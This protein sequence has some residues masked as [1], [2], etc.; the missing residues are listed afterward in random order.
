MYA[1]TEIIIYVTI[2]DCQPHIDV[3]FLNDPS[4]GTNEEES[5]GPVHKSVPFC[6]M[7][8]KKRFWADASSNFP[9]PLNYP[10]SKSM[11]HP[12]TAL[13]PSNNIPHTNSFTK[14]GRD[15]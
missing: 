2:G 7:N 12:H 9:S 13:N 15:E 6:P 3:G 5:D 10:T 4:D 1:T 8:E 11:I 14:F